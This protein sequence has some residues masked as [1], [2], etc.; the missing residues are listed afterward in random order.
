MEGNV[1]VLYLIILYLGGIPMAT[2]Q[3]CLNPFA[4]S[5]DNEMGSFLC[6]CV[7][8]VK[9]WWCTWLLH[10]FG[11]YTWCGQ[12]VRQNVIVVSVSNL[13]TAKQS[14]HLCV[15]SCM[16]ENV[17]DVGLISSECSNA[18]QEK[19][20]S[21]VKKSRKDIYQTC[22]V[23]ISLQLPAKMEI[24]KQRVCHLCGCPCAHACNHTPRLVGVDVHR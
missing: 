5:H 7:F 2:A 15:G 23:T 22:E 8:R 11:V 13:F 12:A 3:R 9:F 24:A 18:V 21:E 17:M 14:C 1:S 19:S 4:R 10:A 20:R 6:V 16:Q